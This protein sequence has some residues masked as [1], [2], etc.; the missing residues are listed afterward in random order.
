MND[1][2]RKNGRNLGMMQVAYTCPRCGATESHSNY[3]KPY[4]CKCGSLMIAQVGLARSK[5]ETRLKDELY[6]TRITLKRLYGAACGEQ[7]YEKMVCDLFDDF[8]KR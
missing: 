4:L 8:I 5:L 7:L 3:P 1:M 2:R 6:R